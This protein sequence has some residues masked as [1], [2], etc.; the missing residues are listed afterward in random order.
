MR[1]TY[2]ILG[3][4]TINKKNSKYQMGSGVSRD[5]NDT[6][7]YVI[8]P[9]TNPYIGNDKVDYYA[10]LVGMDDRNRAAAKVLV[11]G[12]NEAFVKH[13]FTGDSGET[14]SYAEMRA[15]FG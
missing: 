10:D 7:K 4:T 11:N 9:E 8:K 14:L 12:G 5:G 13:V 2:G 1:I 15:R 6:I 3:G